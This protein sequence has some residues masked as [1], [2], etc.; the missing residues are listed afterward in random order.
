[1][2]TAAAAEGRRR[3][4]GYGRKRLRIASL[5][6]FAASSAA[7]AWAT[8]VKVLIAARAVMGRGEAMITPVAFAVLPAAWRPWFTASSKPSAAAGATPGARRPHH[9]RGALLTASSPGN[10]APPSR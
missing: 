4:H 7:A 6:L 5:A 8:S 9:G 3:V 10:C 1:M 2:S